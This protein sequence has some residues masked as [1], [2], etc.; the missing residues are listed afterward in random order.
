[1]NAVFK[2]LIDID[3]ITAA[4]AF[5]WVLLIVLAKLDVLSVV[6]T[7]EFAAAAMLASLGRYVAHSRLPTPSTDSPWWQYLVDIDL[8]GALVTGTWAIV[9]TA[10][11]HDVLATLVPVPGAAAWCLAALVRYATKWQAVLFPPEELT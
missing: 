1:M 11:G 5:V 7:A 3:L 8:I 6:A 2:K 9:I 4:L 10:T